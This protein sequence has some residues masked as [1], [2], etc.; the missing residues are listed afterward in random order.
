MKLKNYVKG[1]PFIGDRFYINRSLFLSQSKQAYI[2]SPLN[3]SS[4]GHNSHFEI[5]RVIKSAIGEWIE[6]N[7]LVSKNKKELLLS[8][9]MLSGEQEFI[10]SDKIYLIDSG[11]FNDSCGIASHLDSNLAITSAFMEFFER[12][13]LVFSWITKKPAKLIDIKYIKSEKIN[14]L[15]KKI[16]DFV[17]KLYILDISLHSEIHTIF[18]IGYG[19][20]HKALGLSANFDLERAIENALEETFQTFADSWTKKYINEVSSN[21]YQNNELYMDYYRNITIEQFVNEYH[22]LWKNGSEIDEKVYNKNRSEVDFSKSL[23][24]ISYDLNIIP[25]CI[26]IPCFTDNFKTKIVKVFSP[27]G[28]PH[29]YPKIFSEKET[30]IDFNKNIENFPNAY[31]MIPFP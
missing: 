31:R 17:D 28:Y 27:N 24:A 20:V 5:N 21:I 13:S 11:Q 15:Y 23:E 16:F 1:E 4:N 25:Y 22:F 3:S 14:N 2:S 30:K 10:S 29:M 8:F 19:E 18:I 12:Q 7:T 6:R 9:N 26:Y